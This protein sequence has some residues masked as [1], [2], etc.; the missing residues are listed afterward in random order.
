M[1]HQDVTNKQRGKNP[2]SSASS[3]I[4]THAAGSGLDFLGLFL[5]LFLCS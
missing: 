3:G 2:V 4:L 1:I 5:L